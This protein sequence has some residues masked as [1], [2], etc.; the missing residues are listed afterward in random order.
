M[1]TKILQKCVDE[2]NKD[3]PAD[4]SYIKG[5]LETLIALEES[6]PQAAYIPKQGT[7]LASEVL[8]PTP[9]VNEFPLTPEE[10]AVANAMDSAIMGVKPAKVSVIEKNITL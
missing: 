7:F 4:L 6:K 3:T 5:M 10:Q 9:V 2:L 1:Q 8:K